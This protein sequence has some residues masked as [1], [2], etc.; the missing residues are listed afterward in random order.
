RSRHFDLARGRS[1]VPG[2][3]K[4][5]GS[6]K[7]PMWAGGW[8]VRRSWGLTYPD[9]INLAPVSAASTIPL[10]PGKVTSSKNPGNEPPGRPHVAPIL[11]PKG[12]LQ[13][14]PPRFDRV[15]VGEGHQA[16]D[17]G[18]HRPVLRG[19]P[20]PRPEQ[21]PPG[22]ARVTHEP[23]RPRPDDLLALGQA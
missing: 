11:V 14:G 22:I 23:V 19:H 3:P 20:G 5:T 2:Q 8:C 17:D 18:G 9:S 6:G 21:D 4:W 7:F 13:Q 1:S 16:E 10:E 15:G 12:R